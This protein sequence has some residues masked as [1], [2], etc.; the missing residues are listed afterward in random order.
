MNIL[1]GMDPSE[2]GRK[3]VVELADDVE[4][5]APRYSEMDSDETYDRNAE[6]SPWCVVDWSLLE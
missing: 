3:R 6:D 5:T 1:C 2:S 4:S